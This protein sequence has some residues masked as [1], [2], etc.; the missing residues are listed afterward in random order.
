MKKYQNNKSSCKIALAQILEKH[1][2]KTIGY[3]NQYEESFL[4]HFDE[5]FELITGKKDDNELY[6]LLITVIFISIIFLFFSA[7]Y[8]FFIFLGYFFCIIIVKHN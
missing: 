1:I 2:K 5:F 4:K 3:K 7:K 8:C 6:D